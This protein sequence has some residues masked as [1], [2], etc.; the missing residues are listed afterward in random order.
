MN[1]GFLILVG[2]AAA[3]FVWA[4]KL[5]ASD[6]ESQLTP[7]INDFADR[8][9]LE[10]ALVKAIVKKESTWDPNGIN[11]DDPSYGLGGVTPWIGV[12][13]GAIK[14]EAD[15]QELYKPEVNLT[16]ACGFL[17]FL[18]EKYTWEESVQMYNEG[19]PNYWAGLRVPDYLAKVLEFYNEYKNA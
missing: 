1:K 5:E 13:F 2:V 3:G 4:K 16:A 14:S 11:S 6:Y 9:G 19:E 18:L 17:K 7:L 8:F 15:Y 10:R 12:R